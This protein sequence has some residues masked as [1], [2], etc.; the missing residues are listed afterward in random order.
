MFNYKS[1]LTPSSQPTYVTN[2]P[3]E[4][5]G[6]EHFA[7]DFS[8][9]ASHSTV[10]KN[11]IFNISFHFLLSF[12]TLLSFLVPKHRLKDYANCWNRL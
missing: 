9:F 10:K 12:K 7:L 2:S 8:F 11:I 5:K 3:A 4:G 1:F 6:R